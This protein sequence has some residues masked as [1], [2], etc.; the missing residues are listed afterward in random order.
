MT[1]NT[2][3][4]RVVVLYSSKC[5][6]CKKSSVVWSYSGDVK[7]FV[8]SC[9]FCLKQGALSISLEEDEGGLSLLPTSGQVS[10]LDNDGVNVMTEKSASQ[11]GMNLFTSLIKRYIYFFVAGILAILSVSIYSIIATK[12]ETSSYAGQDEN[13]RVFASEVY[14]KLPRYLD[15]NSLPAKWKKIFKT[16]MKAQDVALKKIG[17]PSIAYW[18]DVS[19]RKKIGIRFPGLVVKVVKMD[20][21]NPDYKEYCSPIRTYKETNPNTKFGKTEVPWFSGDDNPKAYIYMCIDKI[22]SAWDT[23]NQNSP[24]ARSFREAGRGVMAYHE[25]SHLFIPEHVK[26]DCSVTCQSVDKMSRAFSKSEMDIFK[27]ISIMVFDPSDFIKN[28]HLFK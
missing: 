11:K 2:E 27:S 17:D 13:K 9:E 22:E 12:K 28:K 26:W 14:K 24:A 5:E 19:E 4:Q 3:E 21:D 15:T 16:E 20:K 18:L 8:S 6:T 25:L 23:S 10:I 1:D 7:L